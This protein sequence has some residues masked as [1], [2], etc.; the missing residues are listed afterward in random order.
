VST[1]GFILLLAFVVGA[2]AIIFWPLVLAKPSPESTDGSTK[3]KTG[4]SAL[5]AIAQLQ[6]EHDAIL[7]AIRDLDFD[8]QTGKLTT[9]DYSTERDRLLIRGAETL[10][11][12]DEHQG[13]AIEEAVRTQRSAKANKP[14]RTP[15]SDRSDRS[16]RAARADR[17]RTRRR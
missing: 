16:S 12:I 7:T 8:F 11:L 10:R 4:R 9:D 17:I 15:R 6:A 13:E 5:T 2:A 1:A 3:S 14:A